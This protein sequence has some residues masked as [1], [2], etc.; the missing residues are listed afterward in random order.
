R[1]ANDVEKVLGGCVARNADSVVLANGTWYICENRSWGK[2][3]FGELIDSRDGQAYKTVTI[4]TQIWMA[5]NL[6]YNYNKGTANS[7]CYNNVADSC[8]KYG[9]LY[10][11]AAAMDSYI[12]FSDA[13]KDCSYG[14]IC[15]PCGMVRGVCPEG[16][17]LPDN[18][19]WRTLWTA[20]GETST[21]GNMLKFT[22]GWSYD[23]NGSNFYGFAVLPAGYRINDGN[24]KGVGTRTYFWGSTEVVDSYYKAYCW[25]FTDSDDV[26]LLST[27]KAWALSVR[28]VKD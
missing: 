25:K 14:K 5:E 16:W 13:G 6:N 20:V 22:D 1:V 8:T 12:L 2:T 26:S 9:R 18:D 7:Y 15:S 10:T 11:W 21:A 17:H 24:Y 23:G 3:N 27:E 4:G 28:C 19:E